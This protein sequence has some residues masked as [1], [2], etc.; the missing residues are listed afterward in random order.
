AAQVSGSGNSGQGLRRQYTEIGSRLAPLTPYPG[1]PLLDV[2]SLAAKVPF[3]SFTTCHFCISFAIEGHS[4]TRRG[5]V[6]A[7]VSLRG[8]R[9]TLLRRLV[10]E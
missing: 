3:W 5:G 4:R 8:F 1:R 2:A 6:G 10:L 9:D 7:V